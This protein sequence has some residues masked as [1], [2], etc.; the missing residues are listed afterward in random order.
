MDDP[1]VDRRQH[2]DTNL[3]M[4]IGGLVS[5]VDTLSTSVASLDVKVDGMNRKLDRF[6]GVLAV[7]RYLGVGGVSIAIVALLKSFGAQL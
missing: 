1:T 6:E 4:Q 7:V 3:A 2:L 5:K